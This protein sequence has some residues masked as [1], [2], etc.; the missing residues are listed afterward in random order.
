VTRKWEDKMKTFNAAEMEKLRG[1]NEGGAHP[2]NP[3]TPP[4]N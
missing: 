2:V 3:N 4:P 1:G